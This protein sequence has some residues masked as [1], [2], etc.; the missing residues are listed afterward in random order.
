VAPKDRDARDAAASGVS[1]KPAKRGAK[2]CVSLAVSDLFHSRDREMRGVRP[3]FL[4]DPQ[5]Q[6]S[7]RQFRVQTGQRLRARL[8]SQPEHSRCARWRK[9]AKARNVGIEDGSGE[10]PI[11]CAQDLISP[12]VGHV[13]DEPERDVKVGSGNPPR[14]DTISNMA[15]Q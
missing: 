4:L 6:Q 10:R 14:V 12:I 13:S 11:H 1:R 7:W 9:G 15:A 2:A 5:G 8:H 3:A